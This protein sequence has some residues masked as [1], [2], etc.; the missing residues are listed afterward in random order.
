M[1]LVHLATLSG[2]YW[3]LLMLIFADNAV[4]YWFTLPSL[5]IIICH[6]FVERNA[7][8]NFWWYFRGFL[9]LLWWTLAN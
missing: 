9:P 3:A 8:K 7:P 1:A 6:D 2:F 4:W 5:L